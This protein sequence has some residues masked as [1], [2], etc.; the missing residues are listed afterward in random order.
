MWISIKVILHLKLVGFFG[1]KE[2]LILY[3]ILLINVLDD[4]CKESFNYDYNDLKMQMIKKLA[5][6]LYKFDLITKP[7]NLSSFAKES[8][9]SAYKTIKIIREQIN[10][11]LNPKQIKCLGLKYNFDIDKG[12]KFNKNT[13]FFKEIN[14]L[15]SISRQ[16]INK[17]SSLGENFKRNFLNSAFPDLNLLKVY[18]N[19]NYKSII[20]LYD[21]ENWIISS[22]D[23]RL[24]F[25]KEFC[26]SLFDLFRK[27]IGIGLKFYKNDE[28]GYSRLVLTSMKIVCTLDKIARHLCPLL[29]EHKIGIDSTPIESLLLTDIE[30]I[31]CVHKLKEYIEEKGSKNLDPSLVDP[32]IGG[33]AFSAKFA[34]SNSEMQKTKRNIWIYIDSKIQEKFAEVE[35][36]R[37]EYQNILKTGHEYKLNRVG[38]Y[39]HNS[40]NCLLCYAS[41]MKVHTYEKPLPED[42]T[43]QNIVVFELRIPIL[44]GVLRESIHLFKNLVLQ[45]F[46]TGSDLHGRWVENLELKQFSNKEIES[47]SFDFTLGSIHKPFSVSHYSSLHKH[48]N[49]DL[50]EFI[51]PNA[52]TLNYCSKGLRKSCY[53][54][55]TGFENNCIHKA[56]P[57]YHVLQWTL[58]ST[59]HNENDVIARQSECPRGLDLNEFINFGCFRAGQNL[60]LKNLLVALETRSLSFSE[61]GVYALIAQSLWE[62][63]QQNKTNEKKLSFYRFINL[64]SHAD[65]Y[66]DVYLNNLNGVLDDFIEVYSKKWDE[67]IVLL[68]VVI[69]LNRVIQFSPQKNWGAKLRKCKTIANDWVAQI[70]RI[71]ENLNSSNKDELLKLKEKLYQVLCILILTHNIDRNGFKFVMSEKEDVLIWL[72]SMYKINNFNSIYGISPADAFSE[73]LKRS[74]DICMVNIEDEFNRIVIKNEFRP[75]NHFLNLKWSDAKKGRIQNWIKDTCTFKASHIQDR[76][77]IR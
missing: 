33:K 68:I 21:V 69:I 51:L 66:K 50:N 42:E 60:Q 70:E 74:V 1:E 2:G 45:T 3:K 52:N 26:I 5:R 34:L 30:H 12:L 23:S 27:Y 17:T 53:Y 38:E 71:I 62:I 13:N 19:P 36:K 63:G 10:T 64:G 14:R 65:L 4:L 75:L 20:E 7:E 28:V 9:D 15:I 16:E 77:I 35:K 47:R 59:H 43:E 11:D 41:D 40:N 57:P 6:R 55:Q 18:E 58:N 25:S 67:H 39:C 8:L 44:I 48:P 73:N 72:D 49:S 61:K 37:V 24:I 54:K 56:H 29:N 22:L 32:D 76:Q 31:K 46:I